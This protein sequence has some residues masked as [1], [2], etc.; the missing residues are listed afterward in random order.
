MENLSIDGWFG[1]TPISE[2][3]HILPV[4]KNDS[5][6]M[7]KQHFNGG[8]IFYQEHVGPNSNWGFS[9]RD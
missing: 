5:F 7:V 2:N 9:I 6:S 1:G 3:L 4:T 8:C